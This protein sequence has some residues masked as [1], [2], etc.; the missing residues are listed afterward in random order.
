GDVLFTLTRLAGKLGIDAEQALRRANT[1]FVGRFE[2]MEDRIADHGEK[3]S[4][5]TLSQMNQHWEAVK[6]GQAEPKR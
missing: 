5:L 3:L 6:R 4:E 1:R 2:S